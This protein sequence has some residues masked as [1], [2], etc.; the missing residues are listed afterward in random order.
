M[1]KFLRLAITSPSKTRVDLRSQKAATPMCVID[2]RI[3]GPGK[4]CVFLEPTPCARAT[5][6]R[7]GF[8]ALR[9]RVRD[10]CGPHAAVLAQSRHWY[11]QATCLG[12]TL[13][14][15]IARSGKW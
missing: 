8:K 2:G 3:S 12:F 9:F 13:G 11:D 5:K 4:E 7:K 1:P 6:H 10:A 14:N 15:G